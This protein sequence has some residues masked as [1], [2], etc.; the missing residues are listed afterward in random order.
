MHHPCRRRERL[1]WESVIDFY[2][3]CKYATTCRR[4]CCLPRPPVEHE[5]PEDERPRSDHR[6]S[7]L[8]PGKPPVEDPVGTDDQR[9]G[10]IVQVRGGDGRASGRRLVTDEEAVLGPPEVDKTQTRDSRF[11]TTSQICDPAAGRIK[12]AVTLETLSLNPGFEISFFHSGSWPKVLQFFF[13]SSSSGWT[14]M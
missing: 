11:W 8:S 3:A 6:R 14:T 13:V 7:H 4:P 5:V 1:E 12:R 2:H 10:V 9:V